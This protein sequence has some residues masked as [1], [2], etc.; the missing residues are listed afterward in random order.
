M[1]SPPASVNILW[2]DD[3]L[4]EPAGRIDMLREH[5]FRSGE[6]E[7]NIAEG[8]PNGPPL[9]LLHGV[10]RCWQDFLTLMPTLMLRWHLHAIDFRGHG[11][12]G[13]ALD[14]LVL[15]Y[16][17]DI[18]TYIRTKLDEPAILFGHSLGAL[19][20]TA[21]AA[22]ARERVAALI[23]EDPPFTSMGV[24]IGQTYYREMFQAFYDLATQKLSIEEMA[25]RLAD[26]TI[27]PPGAR[28]RVRLADVRDA[29]SLRFS[30]MGLVRLDP[31]VL[32][33]VIAGR[34]LEGYDLDKVLPAIEAPALLL[35]GNYN[36]GGALSENDGQRIARLL[37]R[38]THVPLRDVGHLIHSLQ[39]EATLRY[40]TSF[41]QSLDD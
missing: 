15:D 18:A 23:L 20:A 5:S 17:R 13:R 12:S 25:A 41:L 34:W 3:Y 37:P 11:R 40:V 33:P 26:V 39:T 1:K 7:L 8:P 35:Q 19:V 27:Q 24:N 38:C 21:A 2:E 10:T 29:T 16:A 14:Y 31:E 28:E 6:V 36:L 22:T 30:A 32:T 4:Q 9:I